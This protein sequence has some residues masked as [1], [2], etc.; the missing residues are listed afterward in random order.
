MFDR[1]KTF[2]RNLISMM[3]WVRQQDQFLEV[4]KDMTEKKN[5][6]DVSEEDLRDRYL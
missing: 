6:M 5:Q 1:T 2:F 3:K 4:E